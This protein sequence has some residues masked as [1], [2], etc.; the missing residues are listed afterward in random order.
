MNRDETRQSI[1]ILTQISKDLEAQS[2][3]VNSIKQKLSKDLQKN[4][5]E[6]ETQIQ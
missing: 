4:E 2:Q 3:L 5:E 6:E 1:T